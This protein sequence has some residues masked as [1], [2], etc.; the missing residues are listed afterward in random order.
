M[1]ELPGRYNR[2][3]DYRQGK[4]WSQAELARLAGISRAAVSAI[5]INRL[6]PS[7]AAAL[8]LARALDCSVE[9]L[10]DAARTGT[11]EPGW[12]WP[13]LQEP[14]RFWHASIGVR[15]LRYPV[16]VTPLGLIAHDG[17]C[18]GGVCRSNGD[19]SPEKTLVLACCDPAAGL[20]AVEY[21][22]TTGFRL[23][24]L[25]R[26]SGRALTLLKQGL[27]HAAGAHLST[28]EDRG[29]NVSAVH[30]HF[31]EGMSLLRVARWEEGLAV[32]PD[33]AVKSVGEALGA[34]LAWVGREIGSG[35]RQCLD[36]LRPG[37]PAPRHQAFDHRGVAE[38]MSESAS[39][40]RAKKRA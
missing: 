19:F 14:C 8:S 7:V 2:V 34:R 40:W 37:P 26:S 30:E 3:K 21:A 10:F 31:A 5:E 27:V 38:P 28:A 29:G 36:Q 9:E 35:A 6:V 24:V 33:I 20:L 12:A 16:E 17:V 15:T 32:S 25:P 4:G 13:S 11:V 22:R 23:L 1:A 18:R 39:G